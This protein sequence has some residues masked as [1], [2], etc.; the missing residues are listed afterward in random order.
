MILYTV[1]V[2]DYAHFTVIST[3]IQAKDPD[4]AFWLLG[5]EFDA[6]GY[7]MDNIR[8]KIQNEQKLLPGV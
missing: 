1:Q 4:D 3:Q 6:S 5:C 2:T 7:N 8:M